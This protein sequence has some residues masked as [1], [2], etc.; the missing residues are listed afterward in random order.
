[1][2]D[3]VQNYGSHYI[4]SLTIG[5]AIYQILAL[6]RPA[7]TRAKQDVLINKKVKDFTEIYDQYLAPWLVQENGKVQAASG[8]KRVMEFLKT[9]VVKR[10]KF[11]TYPSIF[12]IKKNPEIL[13]QLEF[14]TSGTEAIISMAFRSIGSLLTKLQ[15][16][17]FYNEVVNTQL[18]L[19][20]VNI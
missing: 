5:D 20:E 14:M 10:E 17:I 8:D 11:T 19:W 7:Y 13:E 16:Q 3:F 15:E 12:E 6:D 9:R 1:M 4:K 18:A 2:K